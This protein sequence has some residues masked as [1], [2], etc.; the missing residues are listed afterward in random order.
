MTQSRPF[1]YEKPYDIITLQSLTEE[2]SQSSLQK[3]KQNNAPIRSIYNP[4]NGEPLSE[5]YLKNR[6]II[7][8]PNYTKKQLDRSRDFNIVNLEYH[9]DNTTRQ[10][11]EEKQL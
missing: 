6:R 3:T 4:I 1:N 7:L 11:A 2:P 8:P 9:K 5:E 10:K